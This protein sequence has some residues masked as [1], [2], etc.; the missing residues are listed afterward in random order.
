MDTRNP[1][2]PGGWTHNFRDFPERFTLARGR[3]ERRRRNPT[4]AHFLS[5]YTRALGDSEKCERCQNDMGHPM[6]DRI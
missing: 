4:T 5:G 3:S 1:V 2:C 6:T